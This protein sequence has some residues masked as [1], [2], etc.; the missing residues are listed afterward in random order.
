MLAAV[1]PRVL[2]LAV[3]AHLAIKVS[4]SSDD[5]LRQVE[6][7][8]STV[9]ISETTGPFQIVVE[10]R[11]K[12]MGELYGVMAEI[13]RL[14]DVVEVNVLLYERVIQSLF[15]GEEPSLEGLVM[16]QTDIDIMTIL[17]RDGRAGFAE[18]G[19]A[20]GVSMSTC[21]S[22]V[23]RL[24]ESRVI[25]I[26]AIERRSDTAGDLVFG[27]GV[28][29]RAD[30]TEIERF[31]SAIDGVSFV[32]RTIGRYSL[33]ATIAVD[34]QRDYN[35]VVRN[36]RALPSVSL[37]DTWLHTNIVQERF[38]DSLDKLMSAAN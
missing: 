29:L 12:T 18:I 8:D 2:G 3:L 4:S 15:L 36:I 23:L 1:H 19:E 24:L 35:R 6:S 37:L 21:R 33:V 28:T 7:L 38:E 10:V 17:Q 27:C 14:S 20:V 26:G 25:Q 22:R 30:S 5:I 11:M 13:R 31:L 32:A 9:Y 34:S 16:D